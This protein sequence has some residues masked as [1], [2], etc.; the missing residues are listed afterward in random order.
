M[1]EELYSEKPKDRYVLSEF[2]DFVVGSLFFNNGD[3]CVKVDEE[4]YLRI[5]SNRN[6]TLL[7]KWNEKEDF[8]LSNVIDFT[9]SYKKASF[10]E[11]NGKDED[12][13]IDKA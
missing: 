10:L 12:T 9:Y 6:F 13:G 1:S 5:F 8:E 4:Q 7:K 3:L 2:K 11:E